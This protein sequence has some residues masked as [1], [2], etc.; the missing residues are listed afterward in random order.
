VAVPAEVLNERVRGADP[1]LEA[2]V[3]KYAAELLEK[4][5]PEGAATARARLRRHLVGSM[6]SGEV[7]LHNA[8]RHLGTTGRT[9]Q[10]RLR[11]EGTSFN[12]VL[13]EVRRDVALAQ[14]RARRQS[15]DELAF[16][17]GFEKSSSFHRAFKRWTGLTPGEFRRQGSPA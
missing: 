6:H 10:R 14:M 11:E 12:E 5:D 17:L 13:D 15:I 4:V 16:V 1:I 3:L 9:L 2:A 8:A 7:A